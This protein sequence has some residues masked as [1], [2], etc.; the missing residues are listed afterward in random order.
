MSRAK[1]ISWVAITIVMPASAELADHV[2]HLADQLRVERAGH[3]VEQHQPRLHRQRAHDRDPL[4]LAAG[5]PVGVLVAPCRPGRT[6]RAA[7]A[8]RSSASRR[9]RPSTLRGA[10]VT[11]S[12]HRHV[13][14][15]VERLEDDADP[16][17]DRVRRRRRGS[18]MSC[19]VEPTIRP[20][21]TGSSRLMQRSSVDLPEPD[22][23]I[24]Q[25]TS[26]SA[27]SRSMPRS[28][29]CSP[30]ALCRPSMPQRL[31]V[32]GRRSPTC[33]APLARDQ[34]VGEPGQRDRQQRRTAA[35]ATRYGVKLKSPPASICAA[36]APRPARAA[37]T[38]AVSF[39]RPMK[40]L[41][42]GGMTRRTA[43]GRTTWRS[44]WRVGQAERAG[45]GLLARVH[46]L[47]AGPEDL[48]DVRRVD[49]HQRDAPQNDGASAARPA[50]A[51]PGT[52]KPT[53]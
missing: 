50:A 36:E 2:Q 30:N 48:G 41:S 46:R 13:R 35:P 39:C 33:G 22:A 31:P 11:L 17:A 43:C 6:A 15:Q 25:T 10:S 19:A 12:Q 45:G 3:L 40:S 18:V 1:P 51:A 5:Q 49:E 42:S 24:R 32:D 29:S 28:T 7:P 16:A 23:P 26:C 53:R 4:L 9:R 52:P 21:S 47:D 38:S 14:E 37:T 44:V 27:T 8:P 34:P 20:S